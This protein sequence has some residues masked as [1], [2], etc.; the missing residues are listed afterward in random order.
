MPLLITVLYFVFCVYVYLFLHFHRK[1]RSTPS[2]CRRRT[3]RATWT[4]ASPTR[5]PPSSPSRTS[6]TTRP[7][8]PPGRWVDAKRRRLPPSSRRRGLK[9][10]KN[11]G[12]GG[13]T[14]VWGEKNLA[15]TG[16]DLQL[17]RRGLS[18][19]KG[20]RSLA[21]LCEMLFGTHTR[22]HAVTWE[23]IHIIDVGEHET[24]AS[25]SVMIAGLI[26][27]FRMMITLHRVVSEIELK[28]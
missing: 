28:N 3:W 6:T 24:R 21:P 26:A 22:T 19:V 4:S 12:G 14:G 16:G 20:G 9:R 8:W 15:S 7:C 1:C 27:I 18:R 2:S 13:V 5:P 10:E 11:D 23:L 17:D 25:A